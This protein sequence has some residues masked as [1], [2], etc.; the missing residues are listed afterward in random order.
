GRG[1][2]QR[3]EMRRNE[4]PRAVDFGKD[5]VVGRRRAQAGGHFVRTF[6]V[7]D[8][9]DRLRAGLMPA[10]GAAF[11]FSAARRSFSALM[12]ARRYTRAERNM[13]R[14]WRRRLCSRANS[15]ELR[16]RSKRV[17]C[18]ISGSMRRVAQSVDVFRREN[19]RRRCR[20]VAL[21]L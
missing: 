8:E 4:P 9:R 5:E 18:L 3:S 2:R 17:T 19:S 13:A 16:R 11:G 12:F 20:S 10:D 6:A 14:P 7:F 1:M 21:Y 15:G